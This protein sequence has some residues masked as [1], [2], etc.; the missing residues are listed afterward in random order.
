MF[1]A[2]SASKEARGRRAGGIRGDVPSGAIS[3]RDGCRVV[4]R[5]SAFVD[6]LLGADRSV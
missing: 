3:I 4:A 1:D 2:A 6:G 5:G